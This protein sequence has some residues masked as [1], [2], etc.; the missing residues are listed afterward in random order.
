M[1][2][3]ETWWWRLTPCSTAG[4]RSARWT[5][6]WAGMLRGVS[7]VVVVRL[8]LLT[9]SACSRFCHALSTL[10]SLHSTAR[11]GCSSSTAPHAT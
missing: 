5:A 4:E 11:L 3:Y 2:W 9:L 8:F 1:H 7:E 6:L 10:C